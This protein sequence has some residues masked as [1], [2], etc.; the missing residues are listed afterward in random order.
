MK[1]DN[2]LLPCPFCGSLPERYISNDILHITC[3]NCVSIGFHNHVR[4]GCLADS[5]W[6]TRVIKINKD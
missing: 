4:F 3:N 6:N 1:E 5:Q 2:D